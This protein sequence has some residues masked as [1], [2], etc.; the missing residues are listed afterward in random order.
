M[1]KN[2]KKRTWVKKYKKLSKVLSNVSSLESRVTAY[3]PRIDSCSR[4]LN[5][6]CKN[7][8]N[9][10]TYS[11][12]HGLFVPRLKKNNNSNNNKRKLLFHIKHSKHSQPTIQRNYLLKIF[13]LQTSILN[14]LQ[15]FIHV[16][17]FISNQVA[18]G[19]MLK[20]VQILSNL[21]SNLQ[22]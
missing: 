22:H 19:L 12:I 17:I 2:F 20:M 1:I 11:K 8:N 13:T 10:Q 7:C 16:F 3:A 15:S 6:K 9:Y 5:V 14:Q 4:L 18:K 21:L